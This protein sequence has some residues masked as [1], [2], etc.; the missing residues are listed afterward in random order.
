MDNIGNKSLFFAGCALL[1]L[2]LVNCIE[3]LFFLDSIPL[4]IIESLIVGLLFY[5]AVSAVSKNRCDDISARLSIPWILLFSVFASYKIIYFYMENITKMAFSLAFVLI[6]IFSFVFLLV[7]YFLKLITKNDYISLTISLLLALLLCVK[8]PDISLLHSYVGTTLFLII[9]FSH[10][11]NKENILS[12][13][14]VFAATLLIICFSKGAFNYVCN[15]KLFVKD[16]EIKTKNSE[17]IKITKAPKRNIYLILLDAYGGEKTLE[18]LGANNFDFISKLE[19]MGFT[20]YP[21]MNS[22]Y[23][24]TIVSVPTFLNFDY[25]QNLLYDTPSDNLN[26]AN[27]FKLAKQAGYKVTYL[28]SHP[29]EFFLKTG[30][31]DEFYN[32]GYAL[33]TDLLY[34]L[35]DDTLL[36]VFADKAAK[37][38][39]NKG[40]QSFLELGENIIRKN[41]NG[42]H[43]VF[44]HFLMPHD[45]YL[46]NENGQPNDSTDYFDV[47]YYPGFLK[48]VNRKT[49]ELLDVIF[50]YERTKKADKPIIVIFGDHSALKIKTGLA[51][52]NSEDIK[53]SFNTFLAYYNPDYE[54][55]YYK[56]VDCLINFSRNFSNEVFGTHLENLP[57]KR[58]WLIDYWPQSYKDI[59]KLGVEL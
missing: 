30:I 48:Y 24:R 52:E 28:N 26:N 57:L 22:N 46:F 14:K 51:D 42:K 16:Y 8:I 35:L 19:T 49:L 10:I 56:D 13:V 5:F 29:V 32:S 25:A 15:T 47:K 6:F 53:L 54:A 23:D 11:K 33:N 18:S 31:I 17:E 2:F 34:V 9:L 7:F 59:E 20:V 21:D 44:M 38:V 3:I 43:L 27:L 36:N 50:T 12:F 39:R 55:E 40:F 4:N 58:R 41:Q 45:P 1:T 37:K